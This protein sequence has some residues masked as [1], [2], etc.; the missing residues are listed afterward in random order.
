MA[1]VTALRLTARTPLLLEH[2]NL[3]SSTSSAD[4]IISTQSRSWRGC[5]FHCG[6]GGHTKALCPNDEDRELGGAAWARYKSWKPPHPAAHAAKPARD[7]WKGFADWFAG[8]TSGAACGDSGGRIVYD[9]VA[10]CREAKGTAL[11]QRAAR[12]LRLA[13]GAYFERAV[14]AIVQRLIGSYSSS[15]PDGASKGAEVRM[16][17]RLAEALRRG[18]P[19]DFSNH[20]ELLV[21]AAGRLPMRCRYVFALLMADRDDLEVCGAARRLFLPSW[22]SASSRSSPRRAVKVCSVGGG[23]AFDHVAVTLLASFL[24]DVQPREGREGREG[25]RAPQTVAAARRVE[26]TVFDLYAENWLP[27]MRAVTATSASAGGTQ[28]HAEGAEEG[29]EEGEEDAEGRT[30][31]RGAVSAECCDIREPLSAPC[32]AA[33]ARSVIEAD[34]FLFQFV[35][36]ENA[37]HLRLG[38]PE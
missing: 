17:L 34:L 23:P 13:S 38:G 11:S 28:A 29:A 25:V 1:A 12:E 35:L 32:N 7:P 31:G 2:T 16:Y 9:P 33:L 6:L 14:S 36:H 26:T 8:A 19:A 5:C 18:S 24:A 4:P 15:F 30:R 10:H 20:E 22:P 37:A 21:Y 27:I 3:A